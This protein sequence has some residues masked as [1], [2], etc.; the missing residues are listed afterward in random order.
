EGV[1][2]TL[3][4][5]IRNDPGATAETI[6]NNV[7][8]TIVDERALNPRYYDKMSALLDALIEQRR[9]EAFDYKTYLQQLLALAAQ[10]GKEESDTVYPDWV[11]NGAQRALVDFCFSESEHA[12]L[13]D[14]TVMR[15]R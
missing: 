5:G 2:A 11:K 4:P 8:T 6:I 14:C 15:E 10:V 7:R 3:P 9:Q 1:L 12:F 13:V